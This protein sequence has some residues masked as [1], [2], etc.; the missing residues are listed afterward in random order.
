M[1]AACRRSAAR[2]AHIRASARIARMMIVVGRLGLLALGSL[3]A[4]GRVGFDAVHDD[5]ATLRPTAR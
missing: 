4:C 3:A 1:R 5:A 2:V